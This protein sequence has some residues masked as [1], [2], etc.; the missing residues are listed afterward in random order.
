MI[1]YRFEEES[2]YLDYHLEKMGDVRA[3]EIVASENIISEEDAEYLAT[4]FGKWLIFQSR[5]KNIMWI[6]LGQKVE[7]SGMKS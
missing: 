4:F 7:N 5:K 1:K 2:K 3:K 6:Y